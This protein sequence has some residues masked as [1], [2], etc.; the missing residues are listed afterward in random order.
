METAE[1][2]RGRGPVRVRWTLW[3]FAAFF[4]VACDPGAE[5][6]T[7]DLPDRP[8]DAPGG[9]EI[10]EEVRGLGFEQREERIFA[11]VA[12]GNV[13]GSMRRL[14]P[15]ELAG[16]VDGRTTRL[17][18]WAAPDYLAVGSDEDYF[19]VPLS[20]R[21]SQRIA[22]LVGGSLP[23]SRMVDAIW[24]SARARLVPIRF[25]PDEHRMTV[26]Y[27]ERHDRLVQAQRRLQNV[28]P[29]VLVAGHKLDVVLATADPGGQKVVALY[30]WHHQAGV[31][32]QPLVPILLDRE[33]HFSMGVRLVDR[34]VLVDGVRRDLHDILEDFE[35]AA[36]LGL[37]PVADAVE[38][39]ATR[40]P[41]EP[42]PDGAAPGF[43]P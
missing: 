35:L 42:D 2:R 23:T 30:G 27:F 24:A 20:P 31:P 16:E 15:V 10:A 13:P 40:P 3:I 22:D 38:A 9:E 21:T 25:P 33:P 18:F 19:L 32:I 12:R 1:Q 37:S 41:R 34:T 26:R 36:L 5:A 6:R 29:G 11:E 17:T 28:R 43:F 7:L 8:D 4:S 14:V 39:D